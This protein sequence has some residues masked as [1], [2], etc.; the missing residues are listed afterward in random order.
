MNIMAIH[1]VLP[2][3]CVRD[4]LFSNAGQIF[5]ALKT[6]LQLLKQTGWMSQ[7]KKVSSIPTLIFIMYE[8]GLMVHFRKLVVIKYIHDLQ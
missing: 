8:N 1:V 3:C 2:L 7:V 6:A 5:S 4:M